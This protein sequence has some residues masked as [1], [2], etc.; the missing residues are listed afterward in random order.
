VIWIE[1]GEVPL[2]V[3]MVPEEVIPPANV[4]PALS[5][6]SFV[7]PPVDKYIPVTLATTPP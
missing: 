2:R 4:A 5:N 1:V 6:D 7:V 3:R